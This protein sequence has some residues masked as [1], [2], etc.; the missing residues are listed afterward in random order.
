MSS[1]KLSGYNLVIKEDECWYAGMYGKTLKALQLLTVD[2]GGYIEAKLNNSPEKILIHEDHSLLVPRA[3]N[4]SAYCQCDNVRGSDLSQVNHYVKHFRPE[5][6]WMIDLHA[7]D[8]QAVEGRTIYFGGTCPLCH[9]FM[10]WG[11]SFADYRWTGER[12]LAA[13]RDAVNKRQNF[14]VSPEQANMIVQSFVEYCAGLK[15]KAAC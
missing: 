13:A 2:G 4:R 5:A 12:L 14:K 7:I 1:R 3:R 10:S 15:E 9:G 6:V 11:E 8:E